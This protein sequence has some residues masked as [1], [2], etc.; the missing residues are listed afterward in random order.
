MFGHIER[1]PYL[2]TYV[3]DH[4]MLRPGA[5]VRA[6]GGY[7]IVYARDTLR[8]PGVWEA[9]KRT[10]RGGQ[11]RPE[12]PSEAVM[13]GLVPQSLRP[14]PIPIETK[15]I[16]IGDDQLYHLLAAYD[17][18]FW[19]IFK[20]RA[21]FDFRMENTEANIHA[22]AALV[23]GMVDQHK[24]QQVDRSGV[25]EIVEYSTRVAGD[26]SK[27]STRFGFI[28]D[29][30][31]EANHWAQQDGDDLIRD[32]HIRK[33]LDHRIYRTSRIADAIRELTVKGVLI[34]DLAGGRVGQ[35]NGLSVYD[36][37][38]IAFG[39]PSRITARTFMGRQGV[40]NIEREARLSGSSYDKGVLIL[41][42]FLGARYAQEFPL[43]LSVSLAF[44]QN[45]E[46][47]DGDSAS[48]AELFAI[49]SSLSGLPL[50]Q[51]IAVTGS[52]NQMGQVQAIGGVNQKIE[53]FFDVCRGAKSLGNVGVIIPKANIANLALRHDVVEEARKGRFHVY[54]I[55]TVDEGIGVLTGKPA[56]KPGK[57]G[58]YPVGSVNALVQDRLRELAEG[59]RGYH[60]P[61]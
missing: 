20:V 38:D 49:M 26:R 48:A 15:V 30:V 34:V 35:V 42:G 22:S 16:M 44:E 46:G 53:G 37:G 41:S 43:S 13:P 36:L 33:A 29:L 9:L 21:D 40:V 47:V 2:G 10:L 52:I 51:G 54:A 1:R 11:V 32:E 6:S 7:L 18:D 45:Y 31:I 57:A 58:T 59:M 25:A 61:A 55:E 5:V 3:T 50:R 60:T 23:R 4:T 12:D 14:E 28:R 19:E 8:Q 17:D 27:L 24:L 39:K 56:G